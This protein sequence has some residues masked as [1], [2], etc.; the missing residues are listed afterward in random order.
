MTYRVGI[1]G[2]GYGQHVLLPVF[3]ANPRTQVVALCASTQERA[4]AVAA[5]HGVERAYGDWRELIA[6]DDIDIVAIAVPPVHQP[7]IA[8][9]AAAAGK[10][11]FLE[12]P[13]GIDVPS[14]QQILNAA[15]A[16]GVVTAVD[17]EFPQIAAWQAAYNLLT[18]GAIG[19][20]RHI[21]VN[22]NVETY[23]NRNH[24]TNWKTQS[25]GGG[26][27]YNFGPHVFYNLEWFAQQ[28]VH[29][30]TARLGKAPSDPRE[31]DTV[32]HIAAEL[33]DGLLA[34]VTVSAH[35]YLGSGHRWAFYGDDGTLILNNPTRDYI[36]GFTLNMATRHDDALRPVAFP[37]DDTTTD[38]RRLATGRVVEQF[39][40][41]VAGEAAT[42]PMIA[43]GIRVQ[44]YLRT[45][46]QSHQQGRRLP[47][48]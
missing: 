48:M 32:N 9:A 33:D 2:I 44:I 14:A 24:L 42:Y 11:L 5:K 39:V 4:A 25:E 29:Y 23:A 35:S 3:Q 20:L 26:T 41:A 16:K 7:E 43:D 17:F 13:L 12:K 47:V 1:I 8:I 46:Q 27:L 18:D 28:Q 31:G 37:A 40:A 6:A 38:G 21:E 30:I 15:D 10:H 45:A 22:W 36:H 34:S 19:R